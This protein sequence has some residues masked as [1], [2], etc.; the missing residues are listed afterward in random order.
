MAGRAPLPTAIEGVG[1]NVTFAYGP[2]DLVSCPSKVVGTA[3]IKQVKATRRTDRMEPTIQW[4]ALRALKRG[5][6]FAVFSDHSMDPFKVIKAAETGDDDPP[7]QHTFRA[8]AAEVEK[9]TCAKPR[10]F[11]DKARLDD[12]G[13]KPALKQRILD[14]FRANKSK[15][16]ED[17][18]EPPSPPPPPRNG[19]DQV[20]QADEVDIPPPKKAPTTGAPLATVYASLMSQ[21]DDIR[22]GYI[23]S[24]WKKSGSHNPGDLLYGRVVQVT[25]TE[26]V[27]VPSLA[28]CQL[29]PAS[30]LSRL[31]VCVALS[32]PRPCRCSGQRLPSIASPWT[33]T[34]VLTIPIPRPRRTSTVPSFTSI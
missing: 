25:P 18:A 9:M 8:S 4:I 27:T 11:C 10:R 31:R 15:F 24:A 30:G 23:I 20:E 26:I 13:L 32:S 22:P 28:A 21:P 3:L 5:Q 6:V 17:P 12:K 16:A 33:S 19:E 2:G 34:I 14:W 29:S 7:A 1:T